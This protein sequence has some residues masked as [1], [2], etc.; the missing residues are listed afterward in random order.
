[1]QAVD[2]ERYARRQRPAIVETMAPGVKALAALRQR[3]VGMTN[4]A[5]PGDGAGQRWVTLFIRV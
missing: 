4:A 1:M 3:M 2:A 5:S